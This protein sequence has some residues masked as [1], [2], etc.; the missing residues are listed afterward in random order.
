MLPNTK[1]TYVTYSFE[2]R[3]VRL[4]K[5]RPVYIVAAATSAFVLNMEIEP[6]ASAQI[7]RPLAKSQS[8]RKE[9]ISSFCIDMK[10]GYCNRQILAR[11]IC[12]RRILCRDRVFSAEKLR[13]ILSLEDSLDSQYG[14]AFI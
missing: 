13:T 9:G 10:D 5:S 2:I 14:K 12:Y 1:Y 7:F 3:L 11:Q 4:N 6:C 8:Y